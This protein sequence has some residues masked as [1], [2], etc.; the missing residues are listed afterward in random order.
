VTGRG[1]AIL[2]EDDGGN[3]IVIGPV[4]TGQSVDRLRREIDGY[5]WTVV[6][7]LPYCTRADFTWLRGRGEGLVPGDVP[8]PPHVARMATTTTRTNGREAG[9]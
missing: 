7:T 4:Y 8:G 9:R 5:G 2:T 6:A 1:F 3:R